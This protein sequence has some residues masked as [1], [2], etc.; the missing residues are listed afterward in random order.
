[1]N[2][3]AVKILFWKDRHMHILNVVR[4]CDRQVD[5]V[6]YFECFS[7]KNWSQRK[8]LHCSVETTTET[9]SDKSD[10]T[11]V[12]LTYSS[13]MMRQSKDLVQF[14][15]QTRSLPTTWSSVNR[16]SLSNYCRRNTFT[17]TH[18]EQSSLQEH[19]RLFHHVVLTNRHTNS[20]S[21]L[22]FIKCE[23]RRLIPLNQI[24]VQEF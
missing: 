11:K 20:A 12:W 1:M 9:L 18:K 14:Y 19:S 7:R 13:D 10:R 5:V 23:R 24:R 21:Y 17:R 3:S 8:Q 4:V 15:L 22:V 2:S 16:S 6:C